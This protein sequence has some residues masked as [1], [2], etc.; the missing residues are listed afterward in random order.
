MSRPSALSTHILDTASGR[1]AEG[2]RVQLWRMQPVPALL[3]EEHTDADGRAG[4]ALLPAE[5]FRPGR[6]ELRFFVGDYFAARGMAGGPEERYLDVVAVSV[7]L[8]EGQGH[9]HVPLLCT[10]WS[11]TTYRGS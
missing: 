5:R 3:A 8:R 4:G 2:V 1:P 7:G 6:Y 10:P 9:Y 11:Y